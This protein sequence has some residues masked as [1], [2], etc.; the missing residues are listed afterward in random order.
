MTS[1]EIEDFVYSEHGDDDSIGPD[2][3]GWTDAVA[4]VSEAAE[5][6][7]NDGTRSEKALDNARYEEFWGVVVF[8]GEYDRDRAWTPAEFIS[9]GTGDLTAEP[10]LDAVVKAYLAYR[11]SD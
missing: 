3:Y 1:R 8:L 2:T 10:P 7:L 5:A 4:R 11:D 6:R 9:I